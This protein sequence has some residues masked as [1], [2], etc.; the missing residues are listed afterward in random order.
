MEYLDTLAVYDRLARAGLPDAASRELSEILRNHLQ[1]QVEVLVVKKDVAE[2]KRDIASV[3]RSI[4]ELR[5]TTQRDIAG[6]Q[7]NIAELKAEIA[8]VKVDVIKKWAVGVML[9]MS[10]IIITAVGVLVKLLK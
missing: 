9:V 8:E 4:E 3:N 1:Q 5:A 6:I 2:V 10:A 7:K